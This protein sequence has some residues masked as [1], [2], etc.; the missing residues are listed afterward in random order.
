MAKKYKGDKKPYSSLSDRYYEENTTKKDIIEEV[1]VESKVDKVKV[2][3]NDL[4]IRKGAGKEFDRTGKFTGPGIFEI[5]ERKNGYGKLKSG[6]GWI[7]LEFCQD[8]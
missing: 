6:E 5:T 8:V 7:S 3:I 2:T 4:N 1:P